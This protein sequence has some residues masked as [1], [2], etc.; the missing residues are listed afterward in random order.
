MGERIVARGGRLHAACH[1]ILNA[2]PGIE[3]INLEWSPKTVAGPA[4]SVS[5]SGWSPSLHRISVQAIQP[6]PQEDMDEEAIADQILVQLRDVF[7]RQ[8]RR[9]GDAARLG[10]GSPLPN[11]AISHLE[12]D[13]AMIPLAQ[14]YGTDLMGAM[15]NAVGTLH[16]NEQLHRG[17]ALLR[18]P[19]AMVGEVLRDEGN[20][21]FVAPSIK[22]RA[23]GSRRAAVHHGHL[24]AI[25]AEHLPET[26]LSALI[27]RPIGNLVSLHPSLDDRP[28]RRAENRGTR[29]RPMIELGIDQHLEPVHSIAA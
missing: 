23:A 17:G 27:G 28:V 26:A 9:A 29:E 22:I 2:I 6:L 5:F 16:R 14:D 8:R 7:E 10:H 20:L 18:Q 12:I 4:I 21:R 1:D 19:G 25:Y 15:R 3:S 11:G 13:R 24:V